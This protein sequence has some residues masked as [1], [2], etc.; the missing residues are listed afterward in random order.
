M[1]SLNDWKRQFQE[2]SWLLGICENGF[3]DLK[4][5]RIHWIDNGKYNG[6]KWFADPFILDYDG[7]RIILLVEEFDYKVHRGRIARL[8]IDRTVWKVKE[9]KIILDLL[10]HLSFPMIWREGEKIYVCP[11]NHASG[12]FVLYEYNKDTDELVLIKSLIKEKLTDAI[13]Y[14]DEMGYYI[15]STY[16]PT[17]NGKVLTIYKSDNLF[18]EY[19]QMQ[20]IS[21]EENIARNA[22]RL[23]EY[24]GKLIRP[25]QEC[26]HT[27]GHAISFQEMTRNESDFKFKEIYRYLSTHPS[28]KFGSHTFNEY[29]GMA[30]IDVKGFRYDT[31]GRYFYNLQ[32][33]AIKLHL[34]KEIWLK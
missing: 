7:S 30:V 20:C 28:Y 27:Y 29:N 11:E 14:H 3:N 23:F 12:E 19:K 16:E 32:R 26:N 6:N 10:T 17:P 8:T 5:N 9:C 18:D 2:S 21:F 33:L 24:R 22:G 13:I 25:A 15:L 4:E 34:K 1:K 31:L